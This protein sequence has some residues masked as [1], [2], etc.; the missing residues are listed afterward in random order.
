M[1]PSRLDPLFASLTSLPGVHVV[2]MSGRP[3][4]VLERHFSD[5]SVWLVA[6]YGAWCR[7][8]GAWQPTVDEIIATVRR[9]RADG[10]GSEN[11]PECVNAVFVARLR[12]AG[13][14]EIHVWTVDEPL[15]AKEYQRLGVTSLITNRPAPL[16]CELNG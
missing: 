14:N 10:L 5:S 9:T 4:D 7:G 16:R 11:R 1:R 12:A 6:E 8:D 15:Q 3:H 2:V 13:I